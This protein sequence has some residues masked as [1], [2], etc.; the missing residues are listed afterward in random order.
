[1]GLLKPHFWWERTSEATD[2]YQVVK[3]GTDKDIFSGRMPFNVTDSSFVSMQIHEPF[4]EIIA[5]TSVWYV[6][7]LDLREKIPP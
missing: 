2:P 4:R 3:T 1:M 7:Q 6:P 5:K